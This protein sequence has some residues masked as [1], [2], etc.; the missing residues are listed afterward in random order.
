M[1]AAR[2]AATSAGALLRVIQSKW[3][4]SRAVRLKA[5]AVHK[6]LAVTEW[7]ERLKATWPNGHPHGASPHR[8]IGH[9]GVAG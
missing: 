5:K 1:T 7:A 9:H 8:D 3:T 2:S 4:G 6:V